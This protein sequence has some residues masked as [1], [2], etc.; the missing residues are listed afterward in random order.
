MDLNKI[1]EALNQKKYIHTH[2]AGNLDNSYL[3]DDEKTVIQEYRPER[4]LII[5]GSLAPNRPNHSK[6]KH[7][8]GK[9]QK[10]MIRGKLENKGWGADL[11]YYGFKNT[12]VEEH[13]DIE[14]FILFSD[15]LSANWQFLDEFEGNEYKRILA[16]FE[17]ENGEIGIGNIYALKE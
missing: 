9:W 8:V 6:V 1:I 2:G 13:E 4:S 3:S 5:Y 17:L 7:I 12:S 15:E 10:G 14:V 16:K 11:G